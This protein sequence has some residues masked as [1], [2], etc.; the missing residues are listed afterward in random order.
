MEISFSLFQFCMKNGMTPTSA[1]LQNLLMN[2]VSEANVDAVK[3]LMK[4]GVDPCAQSKNHQEY[5]ALTLAEY[6]RDSGPS[7]QQKEAPVALTNKRAEL[8]KQIVTLLKEV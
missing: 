1:I 8:Y 7:Y 2:A 3:S 4:A 5:T 6:Y